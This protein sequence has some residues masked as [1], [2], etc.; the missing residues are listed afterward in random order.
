M[1][2]TYEQ[3]KADHKVLWDIGPADDMT[4]GYVDQ[5]DLDKLL[6]SPNKRTAKN[7]FISQ[8]EYW[9]QVGTETRC[10]GGREISNPSDIKLDHPEIIEIAERYNCEDNL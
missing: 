1:A 7:C 9:F 2:V 3:A 10:F 5:D 6:A 8:I 4:G